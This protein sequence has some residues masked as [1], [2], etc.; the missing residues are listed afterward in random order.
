MLFGGAIAF[1]LLIAAAILFFG[2]VTFE[3]YNRADTGAPGVLTN[4]PEVTM[5]NNSQVNPQSSAPPVSGSPSTSELKPSYVEQRQAI[6]AAPALMAQKMFQEHNGAPLQHTDPE[7][8]YLYGRALLRMGKTD[9]AGEAFRRAVTEL[10]AQAA[11]RAEVGD[12]VKLR[13]VE[14]ELRAHTASATENASKLID[15]M[16]EAMHGTKLSSRRAS[17]RSRF[18]VEVIV[19]WKLS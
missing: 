8:L 4:T 2:G 7:F 15:E 16:V 17:P 11:K 18:P 1:F 14:T 9:E 12:V 19:S 5:E 10:K 13:A 3:R 6:D